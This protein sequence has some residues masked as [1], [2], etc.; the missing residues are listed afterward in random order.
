[1][2]TIWNGT[3]MI[4]VKPVVGGQVHI[5]FSLP[6]ESL[7]P[8]HTSVVGCFNG[9]KPG[10][11]R[12]VK[13]ANGTASTAVRVDAGTT[14]CFRYLSTDARWFDDTEADLPRDHR[15]QLVHV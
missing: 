14:V 2:L 9:W 15:G 7:P 1:M 10:R 4:R 5:T 13:R 8:G 6:L 11:H 3:T 12:L